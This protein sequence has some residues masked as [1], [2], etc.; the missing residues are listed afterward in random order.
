MNPFDYLQG[1]EPVPGRQDSLLYNLVYCS[2]AA[3]NVNSEAVDKI[4][5]TARRH[6]PPQGI[7]GLLVFGNGI[8]FQWIE[9]PREHVTRLMDRIKVDPRHETV[10]LLSTSEEVRERVFPDWDMELVTTED[11]RDVL[12]DA[13]ETTEDEQNA[14]ALRLLLEQLDTG[15]LSTLEQR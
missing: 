9:G 1:D 15:Q 11:I 13:L 3:A 7:T 5:A 4:I 12:V 14:A 10:V 8:F 6:N 2:R